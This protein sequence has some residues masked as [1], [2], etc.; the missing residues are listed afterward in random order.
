[1]VAKFT[2]ALLLGMAAGWTAQAQNCPDPSATNYNPAA[3]G[4]DGSCQYP[5]TRTALA[6]KTRLTDDVV[7]SSGLQYTGGSLWTFNDS[8]NAPILFRVDSIDG[9]VVQQVRIS[10]F[11][12]VDWEDIAASPQYLFVGDVGN[13]LGDRRDLRVLRV[14]KSALGPTATTVPA[15]AIA[16]SY[17]DQTDFTP[18]NNRHNF[19]C[20]AFFFANDSLH[21]FTKDW[22][23]LQ[24]RYYTVPATPGT[25]VAH[26]KAT[27]GVNGLVTAADIN[28]AGTSAALLGYNANDGS[29]FVWLLSGFTGTQYLLANKRRIELPNALQI[30]QA[31]GLTFVGR[32]RVFISNERLANF[33]MTVPP[34]L[35]ALSLSSWLAPTVLA[36]TAPQ[37]A[38]TFTVVP[39]P[40]HHTLRLERL[41]GV[42][43]PANLV[44]QDLQGR[45][46][47]TTTLLA[48]QLAQSIDISAVATGTYVVKI[49]SVAGSFSQKIVVR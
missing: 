9:H 29:T 20:E 28:A 30:G 22:V 23:D 14:A 32:S 38:A 15:E 1:M 44:L 43:G 3:V 49:I 27:F 11:D 37:A 42:G 10:N 25:Y 48:S 39:N 13:N 40:A 5:L 34:Q 24:T 7:E 45:T 36:T 41:A 6:V 4:N 8:G 12:N 33:L 31:E 21:L 35:Y 2:L 46:I 17:P 18:R 16:F 26:L 19:D 47:L